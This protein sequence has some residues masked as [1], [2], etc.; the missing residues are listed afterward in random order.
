M[1]YAKLQI[2]SP[3]EGPNAL[4]DRRRVSGRLSVLDDSIKQHAF[5]TV[6]L[7][8]RGKIALSNWPIQIS[9]LNFRHHRI[10][11][12]REDEPGGY[13][14][15]DRHQSSWRFPSACHFMPEAIHPGILC[16]FL[17][18]ASD[19]CICIDRDQQKSSL[20]NRH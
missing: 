7:C 3:A 11:H 15:P 19:T 12:R 16:G 10:L 8:F 18:S 2:S 1:I 14:H 4:H 5:D 9:Y 17:L 6:Q 20:D 13:Y